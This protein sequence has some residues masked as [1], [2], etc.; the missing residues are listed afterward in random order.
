MRIGQIG[1]M[2]RTFASGLY[3][4][5]FVLKERETVKCA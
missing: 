2:A 1:S 4:F 3:T 5:G